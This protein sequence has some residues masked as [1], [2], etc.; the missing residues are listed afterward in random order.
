MHILKLVYHII[1]PASRSLQGM[2]IDL[3]GFGSLTVRLTVHVSFRSCEQ[4]LK[5]HWQILYKDSVD[6]A[7]AHGIP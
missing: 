6:F 5:K 4:I 2:A 3:A 7:T 1:D